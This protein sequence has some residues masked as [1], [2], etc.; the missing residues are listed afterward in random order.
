MIVESRSR[1]LKLPPTQNIGTDH[2]SMRLTDRISFSRIV[3]AQK[4]PQHSKI[5]RTVGGPQNTWGRP[6]QALS[7]RTCKVLTEKLENGS[8]LNWT[9]HSLPLDSYQPQAVV[10][11]SQGTF[12]ENNFFYF[13]ISMILMLF[14]GILHFKFTWY[15]L[16]FQ[17]WRFLSFRALHFHSPPS[18]T[19]TAG[20]IL[21]SL[22]FY[23]FIMGCSPWNKV[24]FHGQ[25]WRNLRVP[26]AWTDLG[27][28][29]WHVTLTCLN[30]FL[31][32][33]NARIQGPRLTPAKCQMRVH[34]LFLA[35]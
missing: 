15:S 16:T 24:Q 6:L 9:D 33:L 32:V 7:G 4:R 25:H 3:D 5:L 28:T 26:N 17:L 8:N 18:Y 13:I 11:T 21:A 22:L 27:H 14:Y 12:T 1:S 23:L 10:T 31:K 29:L 34:F 30:L 2:L 20:D 35:T 19:T